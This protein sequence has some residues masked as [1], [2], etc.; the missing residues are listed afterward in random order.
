MYGGPTTVLMSVISVDP[1]FFVAM[2]G[3][4]IFGP[5]LAFV[6]GR[7]SVEP[8]AG[9]PV[10]ECLGCRHESRTETFPSP[11]TAMGMLRE[12][13]LM[14]SGLSRSDSKPSAQDRFPCSEVLAVMSVAGGSTDD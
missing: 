1:I 2:L 5:P 14:A 12:A 6:L 9:K 8:S 3:M 7:W 10:G 11:G 4:S 13:P